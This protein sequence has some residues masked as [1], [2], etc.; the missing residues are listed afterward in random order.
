MQNFRLTIA[1]S[2][3]IFFYCFAPMFTICSEIC[4]IRSNWLFHQAFI[5]H[6]MHLPLFLVYLALPRSSLLTYLLPRFSCCLL[7]FHLCLFCPPSSHLYGFLSLVFLCLK[8]LSLLPPH[9]TYP[10]LKPLTQ[11]QTQTLNL[12]Q[13]LTLN[14]TLTLTLTQTLT[15]SFTLTLTLTLTLIDPLSSLLPP[16][17]SLLHSPSYHLPPRCSLLPPPTP[18]LHPNHN[19]NP[20]P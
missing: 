15:R 1:F 11:T 18:S 5:H 17:F 10:K 4:F 12:S 16:P 8:P 3:K 14:L 7:Y 9:F 20:T 2:Y 6:E 13:T 19:L